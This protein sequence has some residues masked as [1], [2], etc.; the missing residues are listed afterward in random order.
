M[1]RRE[2]I[3]L[4]GGAAV[5]WPL[6]AH[7]QQRAKV[8]QIGFIAGGSRALSFSI[9]AAFPQ[10]MRELGYVE[11]KDFIMEW[12]FADADY[13]RIPGFAAELIQSKVD[14]FVLGTG[15][16]IARYNDRS[17][18]VE[19]RMTSV[20]AQPRNLNLVSGLSRKG[21]SLFPGK[22]PLGLK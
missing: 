18:P 19:D 5:A 16:A 20:W 17:H 10:G 21:A 11:G 13:D 14:V 3:T 8:W 15:A 1:I 7:G 6:L 4:L 22:L 9:V 2:F 12:R